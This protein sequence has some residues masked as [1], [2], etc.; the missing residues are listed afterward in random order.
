MLPFELCSNCLHS[1]FMSNQP[2]LRSPTPKEPSGKGKGESKTSPTPK[3]FS[4]KGKGGRLTPLTPNESLA[5]G[6]GDSLTTPT[7][8]EFSGK[9]K[10]DSETSPI[11]NEFS[12][13]EKGDSVKSPTPNKFSGK[14]KGDSVK[15][16]TPN[17]F[18]GKGKGDSETSLT[19]NEFSGKEKRDSVKSPTPKESSE[20]QRGDSFEDIQRKRL[21]KYYNIDTNRILDEGDQISVE[22]VPARKKLNIANLKDLY[23]HDGA[24]DESSPFLQLLKDFNKSKTFVNFLHFTPPNWK[25]KFNISMVGDVFNWLTKHQIPNLY[26]EEESKDFRGRVQDSKQTKTTWN[27]ENIYW[28]PKREL[29]IWALFMNQFDLADKFWRL[30]DHEQ[31][32]GAL[33]ASLLLR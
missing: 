16:P 32:G 30:L 29:F 1:E 15:S 20:N 2:S 14:E 28:N 17:E 9:G 25:H 4:G 5:K 6:K 33:T 13:K 21:S 24:T 27:E 19:P 23:S 26:E 10:G 12:G 18:S 22:E 31:I 8:E 3:E 7:P 11:P